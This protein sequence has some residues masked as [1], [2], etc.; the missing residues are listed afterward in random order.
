[1]YCYVLVLDSLEFR[2]LFKRKPWM[3]VG[4]LPGDIANAFLDSGVAADVEGTVE[5]VTLAP[6]L[7]H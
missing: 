4:S 2:S 7:L 1:M 6:Q 3:A 5:L